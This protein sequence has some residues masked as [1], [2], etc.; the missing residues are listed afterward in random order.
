MKAVPQLGG[1]GWITE[2]KEKMKILFAHALV[3]DKSQSNLYEGTIT[4]IPYFIAKFQK[5]PQLMATELEIA[6]VTYY[7][8]YFDSVEIIVEAINL[9]EDVNYSLSISIKVT[10]EGEA[11]NLSFLAD[12]DDGSLTNVIQEINK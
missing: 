12:I 2:T 4:S 1:I 3:T 7:Q 5:D 10:E 8:R 6:L 9:T 11:F